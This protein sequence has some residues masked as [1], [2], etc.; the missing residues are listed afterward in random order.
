MV[1]TVGFVFYPDVTMLSWT[2]FHFNCIN[3]NMCIW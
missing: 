3:S 2:V 1:I